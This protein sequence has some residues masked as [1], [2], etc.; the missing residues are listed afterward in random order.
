MAS[1]SLVVI[2]DNNFI[3]SV[4]QVG[5]TV[6]DG[7]KI[8]WQP[9]EDSGYALKEAIQQTSTLKYKQWSLNWHPQ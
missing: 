2:V 3:K 5:S 6:T 7:P 9:H 4:V 8:A 1:P